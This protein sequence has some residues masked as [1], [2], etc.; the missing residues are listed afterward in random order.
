MKD[1]FL[2]F[3]HSQSSS[4]W[5]ASVDYCGCFFIF[6]HQNDVLSNSFSWYLSKQCE[7]LGNAHLLSKKDSTDCTGLHGTKK[8]KKKKKKKKRQSLIW[9]AAEFIFWDFHYL[10]THFSQLRQQPSIVMNLMAIFCGCCWVFFFVLL[11]NSW[12]SENSFRSL[13]FTQ[14]SLSYS[15]YTYFILIVRFIWIIKI[16]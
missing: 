10:I 1:K 15:I 7:L 14:Y 9:S 16:F 12:N 5:I 2:L 13:L 11:Q 3:P 8:K 4:Q 6:G